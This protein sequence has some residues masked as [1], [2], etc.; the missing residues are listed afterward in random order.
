MALSEDV[1]CNASLGDIGLGL[2]V[3]WKRFSRQP[4]PATLKSAHAAISMS[5]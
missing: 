4:R 5:L 1:V 3:V 2:F